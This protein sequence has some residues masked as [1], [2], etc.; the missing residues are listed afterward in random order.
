[1]LKCNEILIVTSLVW[2]CWVK[3]FVAV[4]MP[5]NLSTVEFRVPTNLDICT[6]FLVLFEEYDPAFPCS[7][8]VIRIPHVHWYGVLDSSHGCL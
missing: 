1:M 5:R 2:E 8:P 4:L 3:V 7:G 6:V